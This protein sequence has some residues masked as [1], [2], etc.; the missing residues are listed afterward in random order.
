M[1]PIA[2]VRLGDDYYASSA[3]M[4]GGKNPSWND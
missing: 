3:H 4:E 1:N 2:V